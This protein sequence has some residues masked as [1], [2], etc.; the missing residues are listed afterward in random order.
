MST[1]LP[2]QENKH[3]LAL[4]RCPGFMVANPLS[5]GRKTV[6]RESWMSTRLSELWART[7]F[8]ALRSRYRRRPLAASGA[9]KAR[10]WE[11]DPACRC[12]LVF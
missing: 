8:H 9:T 5:S 1:Q 3:R 10:T 7:C 4:V 6:R 11:A 2:W 12:T